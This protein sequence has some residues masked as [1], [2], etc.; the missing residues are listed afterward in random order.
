MNLHF[1]LLQL[2]FKTVR[3]KIKVYGTFHGKT[4][5]DGNVNLFL[6]PNLFIFEIF[7]FE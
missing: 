5:K 2:R 1:T 4:L 7:T 3:G 6:T